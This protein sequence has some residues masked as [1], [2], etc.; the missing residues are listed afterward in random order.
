M[1]IQYVVT[2]E[3]MLSLID[4]LKL[5]AMQ[6]AGHFRNFKEPNADHS[7][8]PQIADIH[9]AFHFVVVRWVQAM[10]FKGHR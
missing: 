7:T 9:R 2:E 3:E 6:D 1:A 10:G 8:P 4:Q 5:T